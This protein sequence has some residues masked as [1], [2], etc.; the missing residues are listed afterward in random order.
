MTQ[1]VLTLAGGCSRRSLAARNHLGGLQSGGGNHS[2]RISGKFELM[3]TGRTVP[4][5][6]SRR[7]KA[8]SNAQR[9]RH[10]NADPDKQHR[11]HNRAS[12]RLV[13][14]LRHNNPEITEATI[15]VAPWVV[16]RGSA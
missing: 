10:N 2:S 13:C 7:A 16:F 15:A 11:N 6:D 14:A 8:L 1:P 9:K 12:V 3:R 4:S 5:A